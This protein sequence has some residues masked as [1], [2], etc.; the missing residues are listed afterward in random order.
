MDWETLLALTG[1]YIILLVILAHQWIM[2][3]RIVKLS[4]ATKEL[5]V[6]RRELIAKRAQE[7]EKE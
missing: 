3:K 5:L 6:S 7:R 4:S 2:V 1:L